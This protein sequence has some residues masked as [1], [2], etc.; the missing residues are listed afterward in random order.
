MRRYFD[1]SGRSTRSQFWMFTLIVL[2]FGIMAIVLDAAVLGSSE[3]SLFSAI[4]Y[5]AHLIPSI[6]VT[7]RRLHDS[8]KRGWWVLIGLVPLVGIIALI[9]FGCLPSSAGHNRF[10]PP[11]GQH[12]VVAATAAPTAR[13]AT[14]GVSTVDQMEKLA[15][16]QASGAIDDAEFQR[17]KA[18]L[19][20]AEH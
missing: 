9:V 19:L 5:L 4:V 18:D 16:L 17:M 10:G 3:P 8:D 6:A 13:T 1:F 12:A 2:V 14:H 20:R 15:T 7:V 11:A